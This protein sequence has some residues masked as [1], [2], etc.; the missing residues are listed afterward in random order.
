MSWIPEP[1]GLRDREEFREAA[2][3]IDADLLAS[4]GYKH[5]R[6]RERE[7][8]GGEGEARFSRYRK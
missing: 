3:N 1:D 5:L 2:K 6:H 4:W 7:R 8:K